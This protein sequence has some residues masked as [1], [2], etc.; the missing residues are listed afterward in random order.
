MI[1]SGAAIVLAPLAGVG[2]TALS[3]RQAFART[4]T[5][6]PSDKARV[7]ATGISEAMNGTVFGVIAG[8]LA[9]AVFLVAL[10]MLLRKGEAHSPASRQQRTPSE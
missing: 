5:A 1:A 7:L 8:L 10:V 9:L 6:P 2:L 4:A 3:L